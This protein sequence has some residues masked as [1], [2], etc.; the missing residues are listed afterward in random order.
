MAG[1]DQKAL[2][3]VEQCLDLDE[4]RRRRF[5]EESCAGSPELRDK[6]E[7]ILAMDETRFKLLPTEAHPFIDPAPE[8]MP[9]RIGPF[10]ITGVVGRGGMG[11]VLRGERDDGVYSQTVAIKLI[12]GGLRD[13]RARERFALER[14]ILARLSHPGIA[15]ILDGGAADGRPYLVMEFVEGRPI[16]TDLEERGAGLEESLDQFEAVC[17]AVSHAHRS[18]VVHADIKPSNVIAAADG[19][20]KLVDFG[21]ARLTADLDEDEVEGPYP[22]TKGYAAPERVAGHPPTVSSDVFSLGALLHEMLTGERPGACAMSETARQRPGRIAWRLLRGDLDAI[23]AKALAEDPGERYPDVAALVE[24]L[25]RYRGE[26]PVTAAA[27]G[28]KYRAGKFAIRHR[29]ALAVAGIFVTAM[30]A[31]MIALAQMYVGA[32]RSR[33]EAEQRFGEVRSLARFMLFDLYDELSDAP[34]TVAARVRLAETTGRYLDRL[35]SVP[36]APADLRMDSAIG[37][38][39]LATVQGVSGTSSLGQSA[40]ALR[41]LA[42]AEELLRSVLAEQPRN[43][44]ALEEMGWVLTGRWTLLADDEGSREVN[45]GAARYFKAALAIEPA[46]PGARLGRLTAA[47]NRA[48][49]LIYADQAAKALPILDRALEELRSSRFPPPLSEEVKLLEINILNRVGDATYYA[50]DIKGALPFYR[51]ADAIISRELA[52]GEKLRWLDRRGEAMFNISGTLMDMG[53][54]L[55]QSLAAARAGIAALKRVLEH[56]PDANV[57]RRLLILYS[58]EALVLTEMGRLEE[59]VAASERSI[60]M[61]EAWVRREPASQPRARDLAIALGPH[62]DLLA[63]AGDREAACRHAARAVAIW[64]DMKK[65]G[66]QSALD[67]A[68]SVP[69]AERSVR[70]HCGGSGAVSPR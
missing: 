10:R 15:R 1:L 61:R 32:E 41:S 69:P 50:G 60:G 5:V 39:R 3:L 68:R 22:L 63:R 14:R 45:A 59:A 24:D 4:E 21:I 29:R 13:A 20:I 53:G 51:E 33:A 6:V 40:A 28:W 64:S 36:D 11:T 49:E 54:H 42:A 46:R 58:Q 43:A 44:E 16:T 34:G 9:E 25:H 17:A 57:E 47:K 70:S 12:R 38:R 62:A 8:P 19:A 27:G 66:Q 37:Y 35:R 48:Y 56:G 2:A 30:V 55:P 18:L 65:K 7:R 52:T 31:A 23:V 26:R 67:A